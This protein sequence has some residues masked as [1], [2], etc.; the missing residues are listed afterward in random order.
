MVAEWRAAG[1]DGFQALFGAADGQGAQ[2][3]FRVAKSDGFD[4][5]PLRGKVARLKEFR[6]QPTGTVMNSSME[7]VERLTTNPFFMTKI[8][9]ISFF[10]L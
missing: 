4:A 6:K 3:I 1:G 2:I 9:A 7:E 8:V 10:L 5:D